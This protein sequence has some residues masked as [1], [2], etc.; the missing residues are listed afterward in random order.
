MKLLTRLVN[1]IEY[2]WIRNN[3]HYVT[4]IVTVYSTITCLILPEVRKSDRTFTREV[5]KR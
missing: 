2:K 4:Y 3:V 5:K 1:T